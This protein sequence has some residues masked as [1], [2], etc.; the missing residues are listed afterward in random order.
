M[1]PSARQGIAPRGL[2]TTRAVQSRHRRHRLPM[3]IGLALEE[4]TAS[5][6]KGPSGLLQTAALALPSLPATIARESVRHRRQ[7][8]PA[9]RLSRRMVALA[10]LR[11]RQKISRLR[12]RPRLPTRPAKSRL[13]SRSLSTASQQS[14][15]WPTTRPRSSARSASTRRP[16]YLPP[17]LPSVQLSISLYEKRTPAGRHR[18]H[19][20]C[21][22]ILMV[23]FKGPLRLPTCRA[24]TRASTL[25]TTS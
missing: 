3:D 14:P 13:Q 22:V 12:R 2:R 8:L 19:S 5:R 15:T 21:T 18:R 20:G 6:A 17:R 4:E 11:L 23:S 1:R 9:E 25:P 16:K 10:L 7:A 24:G